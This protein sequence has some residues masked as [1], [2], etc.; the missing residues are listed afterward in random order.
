MKKLFGFA[1]LA[2]IGVAVWRAV[3]GRKA[4]A[5]LWEEATSAPDLR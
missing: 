5:E 2:A 3:T 1:A 4:E